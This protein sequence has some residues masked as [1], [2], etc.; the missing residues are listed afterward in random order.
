[1]IDNQTLLNNNPNNN[2]WEQHFYMGRYIQGICLKEINL[3]KSTIFRISFIAAFAN[4]MKQ[5]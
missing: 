1:M 5:W 4:N 2:N 3:C